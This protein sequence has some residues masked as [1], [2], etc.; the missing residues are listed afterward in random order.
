MNWPLWQRVHNSYFSVCRDT[1]YLIV[2]A[3]YRFKVALFRKNAVLAKRTVCD[4]YTRSA[5][6]EK[7]RKTLKNVCSSSLCTLADPNFWS[8][9]HITSNLRSGFGIIWR[10]KTIFSTQNR[11]SRAS[12]NLS[13]V[14]CALILA[15]VDSGIHLFSGQNRNSQA[16]CALC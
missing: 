3:G 4:E 12:C 6:P 15:P 5:G 13:W 16:T 10:P 7:L 1:I 14:T 11:G 8:K 9:W 2:I